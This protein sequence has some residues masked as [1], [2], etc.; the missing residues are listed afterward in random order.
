ME[1]A[2]IGDGAGDDDDDDG[3]GDADQFDVFLVYQLI[4][5]GDF[6]GLLMQV[7][8]HPKVFLG[9]ALVRYDSVMT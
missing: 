3:D 9:I 4:K 7:F 8:Y 1:L 2:R 5:N 6:G